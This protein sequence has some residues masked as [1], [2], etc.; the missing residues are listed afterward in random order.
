[1]ETNFGTMKMVRA[2][3]DLQ[4]KI[5]TKVQITGTTLKIIAIVTMLIDHIGAA[6]IEQG[7]WFKIDPNAKVDRVY[8][9]DEIFRMNFTYTRCEKICH[10]A[11]NFCNNIRNTI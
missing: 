10:K 5:Q 8:A 9:Y 1:M 6:L 2:L 11:W 7:V 3:D 4:K